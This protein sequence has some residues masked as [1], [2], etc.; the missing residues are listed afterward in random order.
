MS[1]SRSVTSRRNELIAL[2]EKNRDAKREEIL[3]AARVEAQRILKT[4]FAEAR[5]RVTEAIGKERRIKTLVENTVLARKKTE[6]RQQKLQESQAL[7]KESREILKN[8]LIQRWK[9]DTAREAWLNF[10]TEQAMR[11][12]P[13]GEWQVVSPT[14]LSQLDMA[15]I[16]SRIKQN[17]TSPIMFTQ[18]AAIEAGLKIGCNN[19][20]VDG[21]LAMLMADSNSIDAQLLG[22]I[23]ESGKKS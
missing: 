17:P 3:Q 7:L 8:V 23:D 5:K 20:W 13:Q 1:D 4:G 12:L 2:V 9:D 16:K 14:E 15:H 6:E 11:F 22:L 21:S 19:A 18:D 10:V